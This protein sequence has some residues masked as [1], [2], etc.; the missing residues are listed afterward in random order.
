M[1]ARSITSLRSSLAVLAIAC[2]ALGGARMAQAQALAA[3]PGAAA[4]ATKVSTEA[5]RKK[6]S[7][8]VYNANFAL[9]R[10]VRDLPDI[11]RGKVSLELRDVAATIQPETVAIQSL[12]GA[13]S[14]SVLEQ[15]YRYDLLTP[16][17]LLEKYVGRRLRIYRYHES[18]GKE[19]VVDAKLLSTAAEP[20][21]E[22]N[23]E[24]TF[25]YP[26]RLAFSDLPA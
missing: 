11:G 8:T 7:L 23:G 5:D 22:I 6:V 15:N 10:E 19:E 14:L 13:G 18:T 1:F 17:T 21:Y 12:S 25:G 4:H 24:V 2:S 26:G 16:Q 9:V 3:K 20:V